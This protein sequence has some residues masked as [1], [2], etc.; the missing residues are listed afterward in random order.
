MRGIAA[1]VFVSLLSLSTPLGSRT[2]LASVN[3]VPHPLWETY[4]RSLRDAKYV[5]LTHSIAPGMTVWAGFGAPTC[6]PAFDP[7]TNRPYSYNPDGFEANQYTLPTDQLGTQLDPPAHWN[8]DFPAI[9]ELPATFAVRP[10]C[11]ISIAERVAV[12]PGYSLQ[13]SDIQAWE[14]KFGRI[15]EGSVVFVRSDWSRDWGK[16]G[17]AERTVY[18]GVSLEAVQYLHLERKILFHGHEPL[19]TD[20]TPTLVAE[21]WLLTNGYTQA[22]GLTNLDLVPEVGALVSIGFAKFQGGLGGYA[23]FIAICP[24]DWRHGDTMNSTLEAPLSKRSSPLRW[25]PES[26]VRRREKVGTR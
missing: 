12:D 9:D 16:P 25:D 23:R 14:M 20:A 22:E 4:E 1:L 19:D 6:R 24:P 10:L 8:P 21:R 18:P 2:F 11:V 13:V 15:P 17:L 3:T 5:D 26:G 7:K